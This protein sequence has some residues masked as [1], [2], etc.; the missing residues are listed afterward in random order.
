MRIRARTTI[1]E[2]RS[3]FFVVPGLM[4]LTA[5]GLAGVMVRE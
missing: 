3:G 1:D 5:V 2:P 4:T